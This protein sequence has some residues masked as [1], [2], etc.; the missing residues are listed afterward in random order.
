MRLNA[1]GHFSQEY[2]FPGENCVALFPL[3][4]W[5]RKIIKM[6]S[7][8]ADIGRHKGP[9]VSIA[10]YMNRSN[11]HKPHRLVLKIAP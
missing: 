8:D 4:E 5:L 9:D 6:K 2:V 11:A 10:K 1:R 3:H 7:T